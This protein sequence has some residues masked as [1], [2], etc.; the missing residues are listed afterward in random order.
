[1]P[2]SHDVIFVPKIDI[3]QIDPIKDPMNRRV[4]EAIMNGLLA[5]L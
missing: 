2:R 1:V 3:I 4:I 5:E